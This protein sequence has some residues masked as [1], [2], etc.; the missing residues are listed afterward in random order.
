MTDDDSLVYEEVEKVVSFAVVVFSSLDVS[1]QHS[2][3][4]LHHET[5]RLVKKA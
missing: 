3:H 1:L 2:C 4:E 5:N